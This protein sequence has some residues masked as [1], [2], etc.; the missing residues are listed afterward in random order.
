MVK[1]YLQGYRSSAKSIKLI[2]HF[3]ITEFNG[4]IVAKVEGGFILKV[5]SQDLS[6][7]LEEFFK[8]RGTKENERNIRGNKTID[9]KSEQIRESEGQIH[10][11]SE[12]N[13]ASNPD[14]PDVA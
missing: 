6:R 12:E 9:G 4:G 13:P 2:E 7:D 10:R 3:P 11:P 1:I 14:T 5:Y 8:N